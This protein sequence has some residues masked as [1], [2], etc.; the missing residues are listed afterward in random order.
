[1]VGGG[2][3]KVHWAAVLYLARSRGG[4]RLGKEYFKFFESVSDVHLVGLR[5]A[6]KPRIACGRKEAKPVGLAL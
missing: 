4:Q 5:S 2:P 1:V 6:P 3:L